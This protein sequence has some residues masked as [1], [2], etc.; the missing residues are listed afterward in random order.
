MS[1]R[2]PAEKRWGLRYCYYNCLAVV[3][4]FFQKVA[5]DLCWVLSKENFRIFNSWNR[6]PDSLKLLKVER[7]LESFYWLLT[8]FHQQLQNRRRKVFNRV[9]LR[10]WRS[11]N[12]TKTP[13][14]YG[15]SYFNFGEG[16]SCCIVLLPPQKETS[17]CDI[18]AVR[19]VF[20]EYLCLHLR[21]AVTP[22]APLIILSCCCFS[23]EATSQTWRK[24][25]HG[26]SDEIGRRIIGGLSFGRGFEPWGWFWRT[27]Q[28]LFVVD[29]IVPRVFFN[30][31]ISF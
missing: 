18:T 3:F 31:M 21:I 7:T 25:R 29:C 5:F 6:R 24:Q 20:F 22:R 26:F 1:S 12:L 15:V 10:L 27:R 8:I 9:P 30:Y 19:G 14:I 16:L 28:F 23:S 13:R 4:C 2:T 17:S 11:E